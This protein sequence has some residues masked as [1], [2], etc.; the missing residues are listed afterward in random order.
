MNT[1]G[2]LMLDAVGQLKPRAPT[3]DNIADRPLPAAATRGGVSL[4]VA[5]S[6]RRSQREFASAALSDQMLSD[7]L[8]AA[9]GVNRPQSGG[10]TAPSAMDS[11]EVDVYAAL[12]GGLYRYE[13][14][15]HRLQ[16]MV[17]SDVRRV[18]G[19][20]DFVDD[21]ALDLIYVADQKRMTLVPQPWRD[22]FAFAAAGA[23]AQNVSLYCASLDLATVIRAWLDRDVLADA[24]AL[25]SHQRILLAQTV[26]YP[27]R[28]G[29]PAE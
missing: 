27:K 26:G 5:L 15:D 7:L 3:G 24:M 17:A 21:A 8:W 2:K 20:Q 10:R 18:T 9:G 23:M 1:L 4:M 19:Y 11:Q 14:V 22:P 13:P 12:P 6:H 25:A 28:N 29:A 16:L